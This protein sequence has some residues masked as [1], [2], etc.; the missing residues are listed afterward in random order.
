M[1]R[2]KREWLDELAPDDPRAMRSRRD[3]VRVNTWMLQPHVM[4]RCLIKHAASQPR[5]ILDLGAGDGVF[6]LRV[7]RRLARRWPNISLT[8]LDQHALVSGETQR[9]F[10]SLHWNVGIVAD[11]IF[12]FLEQPAPAGVADIITANL[13]LHHFKQEQLVWLLAQVAQRARLFVAC[14]PRRSALGFVGSRLL[15]AIGCNG[16]TRHDAIASVD[17]GFDAEEL[18]ALWP[19]RVGWDIREYATGLFTHCFV[20][21]RVEHG[22]ID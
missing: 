18:S 14:E 15:W 7:A 9:E 10:N 8:L 6:M 13:F 11:D 21:R 4:T 16:V 22:I 12:R 5:A 1:R 17:A 20:A 3:L 19:T 2:V